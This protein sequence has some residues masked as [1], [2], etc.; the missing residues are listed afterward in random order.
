MQHDFDFSFGHNKYLRGRG[1]RGL[2]ALAI[3]ITAAAVMALAANTLALNGFSWIKSIAAL[4]TS[5]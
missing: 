4:S 5:S 1:Y 2:I 3:V